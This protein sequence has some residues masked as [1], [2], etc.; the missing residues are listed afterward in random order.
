M[1]KTLMLC[2]SLLFISMQAQTSLPVDFESTS[3]VFTTFGNS[4]VS[5][6]ANPDP[7]G[8]NTS[9]TVLETVHGNETWAGFFFDLSSKLDFS[10]D[11]LIKIMIWAPDTGT[12]RLKLED[13]TDGNIFWEADAAVAVDSQ[14]TQLSWD[15]SSVGTL[16]DRVVL[17]PGWGVSNAGTFYLDNIE[18]GNASGLG[19]REGIVSK[20]IFTPN[21]ANEFVNIALNATSG[22][23]TIVTLSGP[24]VASGD[25]TEGQN[26]VSTATLANGIYLV[27]VSSEAGEAVEKLSIRH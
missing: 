9:D 25:L 3:P 4:T 7:S 22:R 15:L 2:A 17:F 21:P 5:I 12:M 16:Y 11:T 13:K 20:V 1:K 26:E 27:R 18:Q 8:L 14:W 6:V 10:A 24:G 23:F 19:L